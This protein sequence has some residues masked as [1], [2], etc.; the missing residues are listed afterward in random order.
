MY[1]S[2]QNP[3]LSFTFPQNTIRRMMKQMKLLLSL[4]LSLPLCPTISALGEPITRETLTDFRIRD[5]FHL[6]L[7][8]RSGWAGAANEA[9]SVDVDRPFRLRL[10]L[11]S[12]ESSDSLRHYILWYRVNN[13][14]WEPVIDSDFPYPAYASPVVSHTRPPFMRGTFAEDLLPQTDREHGEDSAGQGL[15]PVSTRAGEYGVASEWEFPLVVRYFSDGPIRLEEGDSIEFRVGLLHGE[16]L[17]SAV[18]PRI[19]VRVPS[20][21]LGG[22]FVETPGRIGPWE[23]E[24]GSL[25]FIMEPT[26]TDNRFMMVK[27][28]DKGKSWKEVDGE[29]RPPARDLEAVDAVRVDD[30]IHIIH[31]E[32]VVWYHTFR[33][34]SAENS[35][36]EGWIIQS[37]LIAEPG[38]PPVQSVGL[39]VLGDGTH[40]AFHADGTGITVRTRTGKDNWSVIDKLSASTRYSGIQVVQ[41]PG[42][43]VY[44]CYTDGEGN[45]WVQLYEKTGRKGEPVLLTSNLGT[46]ESDVGSILTPVFFDE[47]VVIVFREHDGSLNERRLNPETGELSDP[48]RVIAG[49]VVQNAVDSDQTCADL[50]VQNDALHLFYVPEDS[51]DL[52]YTTWTRPDNWS[53]P[54]SIV[55]GI[56]GSWIRANSLEDGHIGFVYDAGSQGGSGMNRYGLIRKSP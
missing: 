6:P 52:F 17:P 7:N 10:Q 53:K 29:N 31:M 46:A 2:I 23:A 51:H 12:E 5:D 44:L 24:D 34:P 22:T 28:S 37:E 19:T 49:P 56:E 43:Q 30:L 33:L 13:G 35:H 1:K 40:L 50:V 32:D 38:K 8:A 25:Y 16:I 42:N 39:E 14:S 9:V 27:S 18:T 26:E 48:V 47:T 20:G 36:S 21:H 3:G 41:I 4:L 54:I 11:Q 55:Q 45:G 15:E